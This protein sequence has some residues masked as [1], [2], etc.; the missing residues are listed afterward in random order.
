LAALTPLNLASRTSYNDLWFREGLTGSTWIESAKNLILANIGPAVTLG[1]SLDLA[2]KDFND[3]EVMRGI[4]RMMPALARGP[5][6]SYRLG[7][8]GAETRG[9]DKIITPE[10]IGNMQ[11][12]GAV[13]GLSPR[14]LA[15]YQKKRIA[16][17][18]F[19]AKL[20]GDKAT[21]LRAVNKAMYAGDYD[22]A[23]QAMKKVEEFNSKYPSLFA[24]DDDTLDKSYAAYEEVRNKTVRG[25]K[26]EDD[27]LA[28]YDFLIDGGT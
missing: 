19:Q 13:L 12:V 18:N 3:G 22:A 15:E 20:K 1:G 6:M 14:Q 5:L 7:T 16:S 10:E 28:Y 27:E 2:A 24:I 21:A 25:V 17:L 4:E 9:G 26:I 8:E 23:A 11:L